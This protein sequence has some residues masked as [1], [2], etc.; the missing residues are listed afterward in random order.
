MKWFLMLWVLGTWVPQTEK[1]A[2]KAPASQQDGLR[3]PFYAGVRHIA[4][5][6]DDTRLFPFALVT[7]WIPGADKKGVFR[8]K[9]HAGWVKQTADQYI[10]AP[11]YAWDQESTLKRIDTCSFYLMIYD[12]GGFLLAN[13]PVS[14][15][16]AVDDNGKLVALDSNSAFPMSQADYVLFTKNEVPDGWNIGFNCKV[17]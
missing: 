4:L 6:K 2:K 10:T 9:L 17:T 8:Y 15:N 1:P 12:A 13:T 3:D 14:F 11:Q 16:Q 5:F 7:S